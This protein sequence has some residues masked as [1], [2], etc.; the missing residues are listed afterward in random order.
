M[1]WRPAA[2]VALL[3]AASSCAPVPVRPVGAALGASELLAFKSWRATGRLAV[4]TADDGFSASFE[5]QER[6]DLGQIDVH[7]PFGT[8]GTRITRSPQTIRIDNG[9]GAPIEVAAP[10]TDLE[11]ALTTELGAPL[12]LETLRF[13]ILGVPSPDLPS[14]SSGAGRFTQAGW[15]VQAEEPVAVLGAPAALPHK[16]TLERA[17]T[18]IRVVIDSWA[19][20]GA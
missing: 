20:A 14:S 17:Q 1:N 9:H 12:P 11:P 8:A 5:W 4:R 13:W 10:F 3:L 2:V 18:R 15:T 19:A 6:P 16:V 7:G